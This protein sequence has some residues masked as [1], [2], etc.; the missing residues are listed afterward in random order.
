MPETKL[1]VADCQSEVEAIFEEM[2]WAICQRSYGY[3]HSVYWRVWR[4]ATVRVR[5]SDHENHKFEG[6]KLR[7]DADDWNAELDKLR[8]HLE[9]HDLQ[10]TK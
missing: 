4:G 1:D 2:G 5:L 6:L 9:H 8:H 7:M 10:T 3:I